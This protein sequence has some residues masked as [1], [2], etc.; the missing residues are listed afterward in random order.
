MWGF[1]NRRGIWNLLFLFILITGSARDLWAMGKHSSRNNPVTNSFRVDRVKVSKVSHLS[2]TNGSGS[3]LG[4]AE[5]CDTFTGTHAG[6]QV[7]IQATAEGGDGKYS[8]TLIYRFGEDSYQMN[9][10][11][12]SI[13]EETNKHGKFKIK[14]PELKENVPYVGQAFTL[15][16]TDHSGHSV[17]NTQVFTISRPVILTKSTD[18]DATR[19]NCTQTLAPASAPIGRLSNGST[20]NSYVE[21]KQS[22]SNSLISK[23]GKQAGIYLSPVVAFSG[24][25]VSI[26]S[27]NYQYFAEISKQ[28]TETIEVKHKVVLE[29]GQFLDV[30]IQPTRKVTAYDLS[31]V[32]ACGE[33]KEHPGAYLF[34]SWGFSYPVKTVLPNSP[35]QPADAEIGAPVQNTCSDLDAMEPQLTETVETDDT[36]RSNE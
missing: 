25:F 6:N 8:H 10:N 16:T 13:H 14:L 9:E 1:R 2:L 26:F 12:K 32:G 7:Y 31:L 27:M 11:F 19:F 34:Q 5:R 36:V 29:P 3:K 18:P 17:K 4:H 22:I 20:L 28:H 30:Y 35:G 24:L 21:V 15:I 33:R 23:R